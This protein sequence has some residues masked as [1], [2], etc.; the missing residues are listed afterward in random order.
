MK[1]SLART[2]Q[3]VAEIVRWLAGIQA[4]LHAAAVLAVAQRRRSP[5]PGQVDRALWEK[6]RS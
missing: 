3:P 2:A 6:A 1:Q 5:K 4:L